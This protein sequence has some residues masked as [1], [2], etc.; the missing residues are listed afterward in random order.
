MLVICRKRYVECVQIWFLKGI[1]LSC[2]DVYSFSNL[3][4]FRVMEVRIQSS[5]VKVKIV[6]RDIQ[7]MAAKMR[8][9]IC[10][11]MRESKV[12]CDQEC[13]SLI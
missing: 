12:D 7:I 1:C 9:N 2:C 3:D 13:G 8:M 11:M 10:D 4:L 5:V 6:I